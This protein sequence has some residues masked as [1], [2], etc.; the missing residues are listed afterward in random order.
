MLL[1]LKRDGQGVAETIVDGDEGCNLH[2]VIF[3]TGAGCACKGWP[4]EL[5]VGLER[6][7][8]MLRMI[9]F[10]QRSKFSSQQPHGSSNLPV[11]PGPGHFLLSPGLLEFLQIHT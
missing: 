9:L 1:Y 8:S 11:T 10:L 2:V 7:L 6:W 4:S 5:H 3:P